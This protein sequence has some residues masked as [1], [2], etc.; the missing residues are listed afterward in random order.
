MAGLA[1]AEGRRPDPG[2]PRMTESF[3]SPDEIRSRFALAMSAMYRTEVPQYGTLVAMVEQINADV[4]A[5]DPAL[6]ARLD[7][8]GELARINL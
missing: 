6:R 1:A 2:I 8:A 7:A 5:A 3:V 4:L